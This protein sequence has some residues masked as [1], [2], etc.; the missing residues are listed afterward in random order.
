MGT[1]ESGDEKAGTD[2]TAGACWGAGTPEAGDEN[3]GSDGTVG[4]CAAGC[5]GAGRCV[6]GMPC[7][8]AAGI[9]GAEGTEGTGGV[10]CGTP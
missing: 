7:G 4:A 8:G 3:V 5:W 1:P 2:G 10:A 6:S 9:D